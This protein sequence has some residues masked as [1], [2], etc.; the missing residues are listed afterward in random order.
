[1]TMVADLIAPAPLDSEDKDYIYRFYNSTFDL[2]NNMLIT[3]GLPSVVLTPDFSVLG[4]GGLTPTTQAAG[5]NAIFMANWAVVGAANATYTITPTPYPTNSVE[6]RGSP[7]YVHFVVSTYNNNGLYFYQRLPNTVR[8]FQKQYFSYLLRVNNNT[9]TTITGRL[10]I[11]SNY[12][13]ATYNAQGK[14]ISIEPGINQISSSILTQSLN[15]LTI[16]ASDYTEFRFNFITLP[17]GTAD[18]N[19]YLLKCE[20]GTMSTPYNS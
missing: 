18:L 13:S 9:T 14:T 10:D 3:T 19:F 15:G 16:G 11:F 8:R 6:Q 20:Y 4:S 12:N 17:G 1:M 7:Y 2:L 5:D